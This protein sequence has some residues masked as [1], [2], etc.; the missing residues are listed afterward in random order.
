M[1]F[2]ARPTSPEHTLQLGSARGNAELSVVIGHDAAF[3]NGRVVDEDRR[4]LTDA[5]VFVIPR[6]VTSVAELASTLV[7]GQVD[8]NGVYRSEALA[9]GKYFVFAAGIS[10]DRAPET[11]GKLWRARA[12]AS[13]VELGNGTIEDID[14]ESIT[15]GS[16]TDSSP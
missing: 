5:R 1:P 9:P 4:P 16:N 3:L 10:L 2:Q 14:I 8:Q 13:T 12:K 15:L 6:D 7:S 11:L